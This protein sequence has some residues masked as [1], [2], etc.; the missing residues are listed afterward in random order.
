MRPVGERA[1]EC[2]AEP[3]RVGIILEFVKTPADDA[4]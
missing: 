1:Q 2:E 4:A 3:A